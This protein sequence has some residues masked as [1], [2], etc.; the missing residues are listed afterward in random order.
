MTESQ[1]LGI[2]EGRLSIIVNLILFGIKFWAG[3]VS[4]SAALI[5]DAWHTLS[6]SLSSIAVIVGAKVSSKPADK[7]HPFGHGRVEMIVSL[8]IAFLLGVVGLNFIKE[9]ID[10][11]RNHESAQYGT[12]AIV[13]TILSVV[14]K[15]ALAQYAIRQ[16]KK[17]KNRSVIADGFHHRSDALGSVVVL[18]GIFLG[19]IW[20]QVDGVLSI[21]VALFLLHA[22]YEIAHDSATTLLGEVPDR[23]TIEL[24]ET[25][26]STVYQGDLFLHDFRLHNYV[27]RQEMTFHIYLPR[28]MTVAESFRIT[29]S[30]R[31]KISD[32]TNICTTIHV[33]PYR[34]GYSKEESKELAGY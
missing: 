24:V 9:G 7:D 6:D 17:L 12:I 5:A 10:A 30:I 20:W 16:G 3:M 1:K 13:V 31:K 4:A 21:I 11:L 14:T 25:V 2:K 27:T 33:D 32:E 29:E 34:E 15:E 26:A 22:A 8:F 18:I 19:G 23:E 28:E